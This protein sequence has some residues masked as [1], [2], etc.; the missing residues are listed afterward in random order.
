MNLDLNFLNKDG[1]RLD[2]NPELDDDK[3]IR[4]DLNQELNE[5]KEI[6]L[7]LNLEIRTN[8]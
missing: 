8:G 5:D 4:L 7:D 1:I 3:E 6:R 2:L